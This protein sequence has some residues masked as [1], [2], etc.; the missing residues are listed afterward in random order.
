ADLSGLAHAAVEPVEA[1]PDAPGED[2]GQLPAEAVLEPLVGP[3]GLGPLF[4]L[5]RVPESDLEGDPT[6]PPPDCMVGPAH[7]G[8]VVG[9]EQDFVRGGELPIVLPH[10]AG[11]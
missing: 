2:A 7:L 5:V 4:P 11:L 1:A 8:L 10:A 9:R 6:P 3:E